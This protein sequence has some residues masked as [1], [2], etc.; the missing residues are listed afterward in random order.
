MGRLP[1][2]RI[3][4]LAALAGALSA[5]PAAAQQSAALQAAID[6]GVQ[7]V[8]PQV[9]QWRRD[10]HQHPEL[11]NR[12]FRTS[13]LVAEHLR[14]LGM[15]VQTGVAHTGVVGILKGGRPGP[16]VALRAD[17]DALPVTEMVD[18]PFA[19]KETAEYNGQK[20]GVMHACGHDTHTAMLMGAAQVLAGMREQ[21]PGTVKFIFQPAE[22]GTPPGEDG[23]ASMMVEQGVLKNPDVDAVF[24][25]HVFSGYPVG[26]L[27][28]RPE[29]IMASSDQLRIV[30]RGKQTHGAMPWGG[31]DPI[32]VSAQI[33]SGLQTIV[34]RQIELTRAPAVVT[35]GSLHGGVRYNIIPDSVV[36]EGTIRTFDP[37]MRESIH[38]GVRRTAEMIARSAGAE[39]EVHIPAVGNPVTYNDPALTERMGATLRR[40]AG[41]GKYSVAQ[42]TTTAEDFSVF[43][44]EVPGLF[45]F[46]GVTPEG[47]DPAAAPANHS[48]LF[49]A[50]EGALPVGVRA[51]ASVAVDFLTGAAKGGITQD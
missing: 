8:L 2:N 47:R 18:L 27:A 38:Q 44:R 6:R 9:V 45:F 19:S 41:E 7:Q 26:H 36:M 3:V 49:F 42:A 24:G 32:V 46:L 39:A 40:V 5:A 12:E 4:V 20:V 37:A 17:M 29:G 14:E 43:Q 35:I 23:G 13:K 33:I 34:S 10:F 15:E 28:W 16:V 48:P 11:S 30:V 1:C 25:L 50:D 31:V 22:E 51:M 21:L